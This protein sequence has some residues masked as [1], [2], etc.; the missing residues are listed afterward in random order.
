MGYSKSDFIATIFILGILFIALYDSEHIVHAEVTKAER[1][2][3]ELEP[4]ICGNAYDLHYVTD[5]K[6]EKNYV[7]DLEH[8]GLFNVYHCRA[9]KGE[10]DE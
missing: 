4:Y 7:I 2:A 5:Y 1:N 8:G 3:T 10:L 6:I 9:F